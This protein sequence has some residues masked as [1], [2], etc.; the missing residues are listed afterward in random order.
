MINQPIPFKEREEALSQAQGELL[1]VL[2]QPE[3][4]CYPWNPAE[5]E[6]EAYFAE[7]EREF[8]LDSWQDR[9][10]IQDR[11]QEFFEQLNQCWASP[12]ALAIDPV[13]SELVE[14]FATF[15]PQV[16][17][18]AIARRAQQ[19]VSENLSLVEQLVSCVK[20]LLPNWAEE[21]LFVLA[22][23]WAYAM[24]G[25]PN[26]LGEVN[27]DTTRATEWSELSQM[28]QARLSLAI[29]RSAIAQLQQ[30]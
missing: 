25:N 4:D 6:A 27:L 2:L 22:R 14:R 1:E 19:A 11:S 23:P 3:E 7:L 17:I 18:E 12:A 9:E 10:E 20:P 28:E 26:T 5:P 16:K 21:D 15:V 24:R 30:R 29:A 13:T 8:L